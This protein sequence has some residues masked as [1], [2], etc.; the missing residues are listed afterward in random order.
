MQL[1]TR[2][3]TIYFP[4][5]DIDVRY[6][7][8]YMPFY[9]GNDRGATVVRM[10]SQ[11]IVDNPLNHRR[12]DS[13]AASSLVHPLAQM[14]GPG[15]GG[16]LNEPELPP[17]ASE[18]PEISVKSHFGES[19][20]MMMT[21]KGSSRAV[22]NT[23]MYDIYGNLR[24]SF[25]LFMENRENPDKIWNKKEQSKWSSQLFREKYGVKYSRLLSKSRK[26]VTFKNLRR[27]HSLY[28]HMA[29]I[30][31]KDRELRDILCIVGTRLPKKSGKN[32]NESVLY[33][34]R[35]FHGRLAHPPRH[36]NDF[37]SIIYIHSGMGERDVPLGSS[38]ACLTIARLFEAGRFGDRLSKFYVLHPNLKLKTL[39]Y[40][41]SNK[42]FYNN[43][44]IFID[45]L[46]DLS[47]I[48]MVDVDTLKLPGKVWELSLPFAFS[49][50]T[51]GDSRIRRLD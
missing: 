18:I 26:L 31:G 3:M 7:M 42:F 43:K 48:A 41:Y 45:S 32:L 14:A 19:Q 36:G 50:F 37:Y 49:L 8:K 33:F 10:R 11:K 20:G 40:F 51:C 21:T 30:A 25:A 12:N 9:T 38:K 44:L 15:A 5:D 39:F 6:S 46:N 2:I 23:L 35:E 4:R 13:S 47:D 29:F 17:G 22:L 16:L 24:P 1:Y 34:I 27:F 28:G